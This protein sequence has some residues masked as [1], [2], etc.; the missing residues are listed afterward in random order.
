MA[1]TKT[2][3]GATARRPS[4]ALPPIT[5]ARFDE[6]TRLVERLIEEKQDVFAAAG[7]RFA[8]THREA[9]S[10]RLTALEAAQLAAITL[11]DG[12]DATAAAEAYQA[13]E[14]R[15][16]DAPQPHEVLAAAGVA[17]APAFIDVAKRFTA[18]IELPADVFRDA[19]E[20]GRLDEAI[21]AYVLEVLDE[22]DMDDARPRAR[23]ALEHYSKAAGAQSA[24]EAWGLLTRAVGQ[25]FNQAMT[26]IGPTLQGSGSSSLTGSPPSTDGPDETSSTTSPGG[27]P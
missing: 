12:Q 22:L 6:A 25:A 1:A 19:R 27:T 7:Q 21:D 24:G 11:N 15:A 18:L 2:R 26:T 14:L 5:V 3:A 8:E 17:T 4:V 20:D 13:S 23:A 10:R 9:T 16:Y